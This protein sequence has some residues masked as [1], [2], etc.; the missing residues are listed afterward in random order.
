MMI[1]L[2]VEEI[3]QT[4]TLVH[5]ALQMGDHNQLINLLEKLSVEMVENIQQK[6][7]KMGI[8]T[9][10]LMDE[11]QPVLLIICMFVQE[12]LLLLLTPALYVLEESLLIQ[13]SQHVKSNEETV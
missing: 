10:L 3:V 7:V 12:E 6:S 4:Q 9:L 11:V 5:F 2:E 13:L 8:Q 1:M